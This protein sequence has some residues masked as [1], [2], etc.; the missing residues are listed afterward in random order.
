MRRYHDVGGTPAGPINRAERET[1][2]WEKRVDAMIAILHRKGVI[3]VDEIRHAV[4]SLGED[5]YRRA[6]YGG[7]RV[8][9]LADNLVRKGIV[10]VETL[11]EKLEQMDQSRG[12][13]S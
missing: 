10:S 9:A 1:P 12:S 7:Q 2:A 4:E 11:A 6:G 3:R 8:E 13:T 5:G